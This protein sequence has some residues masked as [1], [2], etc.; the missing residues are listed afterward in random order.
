MPDADGATDAAP[1]ELPEKIKRLAISV[2]GQPTGD[3]IK[4]SIYSFRY[5]G[6]PA[7][8]Q[9]ISLLMPTT[10]LDYRD[11]DLF[12][13][14]DMNLPEGYLFQ[15]ILE[16]FPKRQLTKMQML[17]MSGD[18]GIGR[19]GYELEGHPSPPKR[20]R[21]DKQD[22]LR[23][24]A[25]DVFEDLVDTYLGTSVGVAGVQPKVM[26]PSRAAIPVPDLIVKSAGAD[27]EGLAANEFLCLLAARHAEIQQPTFDLSD[28]AS[29][30]VIE[31]FDFGEDGHRL[32]F[33]DM[34]ALRGER[35]HDRLSNRKY[36]GSYEDIAEVVRLMGGRHTDL[37]LSRLFE[38]V[39]LSVMVRNGD[40]HLK[41]FGML[42]GDPEHPFLSP[43]FDVVTTSIYKLER[44]GLEPTEDRTLALKLHSGR[45]TRA[46]PTRDALI[47]FGVS[48]CGVRD[49][50]GVIDRIADG[51][52][53]A[54]DAA[55][56]DSRIDKDLLG[57]MREQ[58]AMG[59]GYAM[60]GSK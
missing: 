5:V 8:E 37:N 31:R 41:N 60:R 32:G 48:V 17:A 2:G 16:R 18:N 43:V 13:V 39:A 19:L 51:M 50:Q 46:Y 36:K 27:Y 25:S 26:L 35:V 10:T 44:P 20:E 4:E 24:N 3:L 29:L 14:M 11:G 34:A 23:R 30:L 28:D 58:W 12:P 38:Q 53:A 21:I 33:E 40:A 59:Q 56:Q 7:P 49:A 57:R 52:S 54:L 15:R 47:S 1:K 45:K 9:A 42:Y 22:L 55:A 6:R